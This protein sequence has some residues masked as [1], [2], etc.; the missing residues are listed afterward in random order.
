MDGRHVRRADLWLLFTA[1]CDAYPGGVTL[2]REDHWWRCRVSTPDG[3]RSGQARDI[4][5]AVE[6][7]AS[8]LG[9]IA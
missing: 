8:N 3:V 6:V 9:V 1:L 4:A 7:I 2:C 5:G